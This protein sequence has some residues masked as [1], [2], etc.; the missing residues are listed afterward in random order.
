MSII[1]FSNLKGGVGK[2]T[3]AVHFIFWLATMKSKSVAVIDA[4]TGASATA[5]IEAMNLDVS[6][7]PISKADEIAELAT[8]IE[9]DFDYV[10]ID[11]A[12]TDKEGLRSSLLV[13]NTV[14]IPI[15]P[16]PLDFLQSESTIKIIHQT[17]RAR[18]GLPKAG[19]FINEAERRGQLTKEMAQTIKQFEGIVPLKQLIYSKQSMKKS[20]LYEG[21]VWDVP[22]GKELGADYE[23]LFNEIL[24]LDK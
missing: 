24:R 5:W 3:T 20:F 22:G 15:S 2:T 10:I 19:I 16:S 12:G 8:E 11:S 9:E 14:I 17:Q 7:H 21:T 4:D 6:L 23:K 18:K 13:T 1:S